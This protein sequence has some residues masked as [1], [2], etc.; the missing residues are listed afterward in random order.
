MACWS[1]ESAHVTMTR[2]IHLGDAPDAEQVQARMD[3]IRDREGE[4]VP[5]T[6]FEQYR[7]EL[8][9]AGIAVDLPR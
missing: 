3:A 1:G 9:K 6:G 4:T 8:A 7:A 2:G 5:D